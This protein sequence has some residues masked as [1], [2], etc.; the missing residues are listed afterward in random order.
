MKL[1]V[2]L[3]QQALAWHDPETNRRKFEALLEPLRST[4]DV[5]VLP[6]MFPTGFSMEAEKLAEPV[7]GPTAQWLTGMARKLDAAI[8]GS[9]IT[10]DGGRYYNRLHWASPEGETHHYDKRHLFRMAR[11]HNHYSPGRAPLIVQWRGFKICPLVCYDLRFPVFS[12]RRPE[13]D[14][15]VLLY[16]ANWPAA[17]QHAWVTLLKARAIENQAYVVGVNCIGVD[18]K[19]IAYAGGSAAHDFLGHPLVELRDAAEVATASL[20]AQALREYRE[21]FP[22]HLDAD[23][24]TLQD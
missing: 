5:I 19:K 11:E 13:L 4:T 21:R 20:D 12:R 2:T 23:R 3:V 6:E 14:Y 7:N 24:F 16:V 9:I 15:D 17:R 22:A 8:V 18:G 1:R 10:V